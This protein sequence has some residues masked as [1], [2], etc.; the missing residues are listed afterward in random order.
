[1]AALNLNTEQGQFLTNC[2]APMDS[3]FG[4]GITG[5][6]TVPKYDKYKDLHPDMKNLVKNAYKAMLGAVLSAFGATPNYIAVTTFAGTWG[7]WG[8]GNYSGGQLKFWKDATGIVHVQGLANVGATPSGTIFTLPA[9]YRPATN[10]GHI[11]AQVHL[12]AFCSVEVLSNGTVNVRTATTA[13]GWLS[14]DFS[15]K[16][17][18]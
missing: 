9:G 4:E 1:M 12:D 18:G 8:D 5:G 17:G 2:D 10:D 11:F 13:N 3:S 15:F 6:A 7:N 16:A 14:L